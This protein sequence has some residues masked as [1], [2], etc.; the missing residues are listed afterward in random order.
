MFENGCS[1]S[2]YPHKSNG[3]DENINEY[4]LKH[5][6]NRHTLTHKDEKYAHNI[7]IKKTRKQTEGVD[8]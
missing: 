2:L 6:K 1:I 3:I 8:A 7:C 5:K 4:N